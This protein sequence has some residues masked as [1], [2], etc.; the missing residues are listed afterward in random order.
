MRSHGSTPFQPAENRK[1]AAGYEPER[2]RKVCKMTIKPL[3][4]ERNASAGPSAGARE[5]DRAWF[6]RHPGR[7]FRARAYIDGEPLPG[8][9]AIPIAFFNGTDS[10]SG[11]VNLT[12][13]RQVYPGYRLRQFFWLPP[14]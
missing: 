14:D 4:W 8:N 6:E 9:P 3:P 2:A 12:I 7:Q 1:P 5:A 10:G 11:E 13:V